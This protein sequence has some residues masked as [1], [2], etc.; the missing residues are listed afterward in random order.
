MISRRYATAVAPLWDDSEVM[1][2]WTTIEMLNLQLHSSE[3]HAKAKEALTTTSWMGISQQT[4]LI[5][6]GGVGHEVEAYIQY[7]NQVYKTGLWHKGL[8]SSDLVECQLAWAINKSTGIIGHDLGHLRTIL[9][10]LAEQHKNTIA[11]GYTHLQPAEPTT[12]GVRFKGWLFLFHRYDPMPMVGKIGGAVGTGVTV[13]PDLAS[14]VQ[15]AL[16]L[17]V[18]VGGAQIIHRSE[19]ADQL[20][21]MVILA[22]GLEKLAN[23]LRMLYTLG[24]INVY[25]MPVGSSSMPHKKNPYEL[26]RIIGMCKMVMSMIHCIN[27][28]NA[29]NTLERDLVHSSIEREYLP[30][31]FNHLVYGINKMVELFARIELVSV[32]HGEWSSVRL[33]DS[34]TH[35]SDRAKTRQDS[36]Q[37]VTA[38]EEVQ[39]RD[40]LFK[41]S[42]AIVG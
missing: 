9:L 32:V 11:S 14:R 4:R 22:M 12:W 16:G 35:E 26:E 24:Q 15:G 2:L 34:L 33:A 28:T 7:L 29:D 17:Q 37:P 21:H 13:H 27:T 25:K 19:L 18:T 39:Y 41:A 1:K 30:N 40:R 20:N 5:E 23:D 36:T 38:D 10:T 31:I 3:H 42:Q 8:A 6:Q